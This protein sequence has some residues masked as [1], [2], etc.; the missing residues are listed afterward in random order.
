MPAL[1]EV[2]P[3]KNRFWCG[4]CITGSARDCGAAACWYVCAIS[5][6]AVY[7]VFAIRDVWTKA[8]PVLPILLFLSVAVTTLFLNLTACTDPGIIPRKPILSEFGGE[9]A[10]L[11][12]SENSEGKHCF[13]CD[14]Y[15]PPRASHCSSCGNCVEVFDHHCPFVNNCIGKRNYRFFLLFIAGVTC[16]IGIA[17][18]NV[19]VYFISLGGSVDSTIAIIICSVVLGV[20]A[21]PLFGFLVFHCYLSLSGRTT[22][23]LLKNLDK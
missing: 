4:C 23:E 9:R 2:W 3:G 21:L 17:V 5:V 18:V 7:C 8:T 6:L 20:L 15:R 16:S 13:T 22:R 11:F 12:L 10:A 1:H 14:I 19:I